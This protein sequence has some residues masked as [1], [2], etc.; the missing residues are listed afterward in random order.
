MALEEKENPYEGFGTGGKFRKR[1]FR[2]TKTTPYDRPSTSLRNGWFSKV[3]DPAHKLITYTAHSLFSSLFHKRIPSSASGA[4][5]EQEVRDSHQEESAFVSNNS[6]GKQQ[7]AVANGEN[8]AQINCSDG[9]GLTELEK[10]EIDHLTALMRSRTVDVPIREEEKHTEVVPSD[11]TLSSELKDEDPKTPIVENRIENRLALTPYVTSSV[12]IEDVASPADLAKAYM[13]SR[14][15]KVSLSMLGVQSPAAREGP[16]FLKSDDN[17][18]L[19]SP[20]M[21]VVPRTVRHVGVRENGFAIPRTRGRSAIYSM[22]R[23][24]YARIHQ[25]ST[26]KGVR[27]SVEGEPSSSTQSTLDQDMLYGSKQGAVKHKTS[28]LD[29]DVGSVGP[30]RRIR[31]KANLYPKGSSLHL[32]G[33]SLSIARSRLG[34]DASQQPSSSMREPIMLNEAKHRCMELT[35]ENAVT[36]PST[37]GPLPSKS[38]EMASKILQQLDKLVSPKEKSSES[39]LPTVN[40]K[41]PMLSPSM[42]HG[43][44]LRSMEIVDSPKLLDTIKDNRF[45]VA[46]G[47][48]SDNAQKLISQID[49]VEN[50]PLKHLAPGGLFAADADSTKQSN[51]AIS[52]AK[53]VD[54]SVIK[55]VSYPPQK[56]RAFHRSADEDCLDLDT[57]AYPNGAVSSVF[58][59]ENKMT[60]LTAIAVKD[61]SSTES[62]AQEKTGP[63]S[64]VMPSKSSTLGGEAHAGTDDSADGSRVGAKVDVSTSMTSSIPDP[65]F[66]PSTADTQ[67]SFGSH[68]LASTNGS[69]AIPPVFN[70]GNKAAPSKEMTNSGSI[71]GLEKVVSSKQLGADVSFVNFGSNGNVDKVPQM[72]FTS[73]LVGGESTFPNFGASSDSNLGSSI[74]SATVAAATDSMP[75]VREPRNADTESDIDSVRSSE[76]PVSSTATTSLFTSPTSVFTFGQSNGSL[77]ASPSLSSPFTSQN[78]FSSSSLAGSSSSVS[79]SATST[80]AIIPS[81]NGSSSNPVVASSSSTTPLF[82]FGSSSVPSTGIPVSSSGSEPLETK[83]TQDAGNGNQSST[84]FGS[85]SAAVG[86]TWS[87]FSGFSSSAMT[88]VN[89]HSQGSVI[90]SSNGSVLNAEASPASSGFATYTQIQSF[91]FGSSASSASFGLTGNTAFSSGNLS[92]PSSPHVTNAAFSV[93]SSSFPSSSSATNIFNSGTSFG[94]GTSASSSAVNSVSSSNGTNTALFGSS[95]WQPSK[96]SPFGSGFNSSSSSSGFSFGTSTASVASTS[97]STM[98]SSTPQFSF[99]SAAAT[100]STQPTFG[101]PNSVFTF[102]SSPANNDQIATE[103]SM[104][105]DTVQAAPPA[106]PVFGQQLTPVQSNFVFGASTPSGAS[107]FKFGGQQNTTPPNPSPFQASGRQEF[108]AGGESFSLGTSGGGGDKS[109]RR[110]VK[111]KSRHRKR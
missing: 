5:T 79:A 29:N 42:L 56:K 39:R 10:S 1:T 50:G 11:P 74:S 43:Q 95:S 111:V 59:V 73:S 14:P 102:G 46:H 68:K 80:P 75:K 63:L 90:G 51:Q 45:D 7:G 12:P 91:P 81:S 89:S 86:S 8:D 92:F 41:S 96:S 97:S 27:R 77:A 22:A 57:D 109:G 110:I 84:A 35:E 49:K 53:Y 103:D 83:N 18:P 26:L 30:V 17:L 87:G 62:I 13:G 85:S 108:S 37:S 58:P 100:T 94:L 28:A 24:P 38:S 32:S 93:G 34:V 2:R 66:K 78:I 65:T 61:I 106:T 54:S 33:S 3:V 48:S 55:S 47:S 64:V 52:T 71:F 104:A 15:S 19:N 70:F 6:S 76:L 9:G 4:E 31:H 20:V 21:S 67:T 105:E 60:R 25:T 107:P 16:S 101:N 88:T 44:A 69:I 82:K 23:T 36:R 99:T 40:G 98:F 72:L